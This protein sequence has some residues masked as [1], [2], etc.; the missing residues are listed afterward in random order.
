LSNSETQVFIF[1]NFT[2]QTL[3]TEYLNES[4]KM[5]VE[6]S[7]S[8][9]DFN[10]ILQ[11]ITALPRK[12]IHPRFLFI[13]TRAESFDE[14]YNFQT[15]NIQRDL[16][17][18]RYSDF[19]IMLR[20][21]LT[22]LD[23]EVYL[24]NLFELGSGI[25]AKTNDSFCRYELNRK[26][27]VV[28]HEFLKENDFIYYLDVE[29]AIRE[30]GLEKSWNKPQDY[31]FRQ[32]L[33]LQLS[34][35]LVN[36][37]LNLVQKSDFTGIKII[38]TDADGT[39][40]KGVI[41]ENGETEIEVGRDYPG[42]V[43]FNYQMFLKS[44]KESGIIL[45]LVTKNNPQD[46]IDFFSSRPD[47]PLRLEDFTI[48]KANWESKAKSILEISNETKVLT[49]SILFIDDSE[50]EIDVVNKSLPE[51][52]TLLLSKKDEDR[53]LQLA[54]LPIKWSGGSTYED[55]N[56]TEMLK[57]NLIR[58][59]IL[60]N[61]HPVDFLDNLNLELS[62][63]VISSRDDTR[64]ER[65]L[66]LINK[67]NQFNMTALRYTAEELTFI[68]QNGTVFYAELRDRFGEYGLIAVAIIEFE[69]TN[70]AIILNYLVSC[71][72]LGRKVEEIFFQEII[73]SSYFEGFEN[74]KAIRR[75]TT[76]NQQTNNFY[77]NF[78]F[79]PKLSPKE[80]DNEEVSHCLRGRL[81]FK[82][83]PVKVM[84]I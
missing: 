75:T 19:L 50:I 32:P 12:S 62:I 18:S 1:T 54:E 20:I 76:K 36:K 31:L 81:I 73:K 49:D 79:Q 48:I 55:L 30:I 60:E 67:T 4:Q 26:V 68:I 17:S 51:V 6:H 70:T 33:S 28:F 2:S 43:Y 10:Q 64:F 44:K 56:R 3:I 5:Q 22:D 74:F 63:G 46:I 80:F 7:L 15:S 8:G 52:T 78:G 40:W 71:R 83:Y 11:A 27:D 65:I 25:R 41:G 13:L 38:A 57:A 35:S 47:M 23:A 82:E 77:V 66:Q 24:S 69:N 72:A 9:C 53:E 58:K 84:W 61:S 16:F 34:N 42:R 45:A 59:E 37:I 39:L 14:A 29:S 21:A